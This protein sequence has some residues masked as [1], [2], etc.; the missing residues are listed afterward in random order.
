M[1]L[2]ELRA[3]YEANKRVPWAAWHLEALAHP[4]VRGQV[5]KVFCTNTMPELP[6]ELPHAA[7]GKE[8]GHGK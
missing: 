5:W 2:A 3:W 8:D 7:G 6:K 4:L 1:N